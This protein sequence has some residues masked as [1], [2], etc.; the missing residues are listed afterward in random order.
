MSKI[1]L[2]TVQF[3]LDYGVANN[4]GQ[5]D[6]KEVKKILTFAEQNGINTLDTAIA[7]GDSERCLGHAGIEGW[8]VITKLP[9]I[10]VNNLDVDFWVNNHINNSLIRL[11]VL[12]VS[13]VLLHRP[14]QLLESYGAQLWGALEKLKDK[15]IIKKIGFSVYSPDDLDKLWKSGFI[16]DIVQAPYNIFDQRIKSSGWLEKLNYN[17]VEVHTRSVFLQGL[18]LMPAENRPKYFTKWQHIF[19]NWDLWLENNNISGLNAALN[20]ALSEN[21]IHKTI[22]GVESPSQLGEV[23]SV[24]KKCNLDVPRT[25]SSSDD[26]LINPSLWSI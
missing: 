15:G 14:L 23:I 25:L 11:K 24:I 7:Y 13:G 26:M 1:I 19:D 3:G 10:S 21:L 12:S 2:G 8:N 20:F 4:I 16:P 17:K 18:L 22:V 6:K 9:E 5:V